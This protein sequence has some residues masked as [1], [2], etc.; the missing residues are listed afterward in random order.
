MTL[1]IGHL[2]DLH[3]NGSGLRHSKFETAL[4]RAKQLGAK[5]IVLTGDLTASGKAEEFSELAWAL[6]YLKD[7]E[8]TIVPGNH[9]AGKEFDRA[10]EGPS[11]GRFR[12]TSKEPVVLE[13]VTIF[14]VDT[15]FHKRALIFRALGRVSGHNLP[16]SKIIE[17]ATARTTIIA[18]HHGPQSHP[19]QW[20][21]GLVERERLNGLLAS[22]PNLHVICGHDHRIFD[23]GRVHVAAAV[24]H[25]SDP[26]RL[27]EAS[28]TGFRPTYQSRIE[29]NYFTL[30]RI[31]IPRD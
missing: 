22:L 6:R 16:V 4:K 5:H 1:L 31:H 17:H 28:S 13:G 2:T 8:V 18:A 23:I 3:L 30:G 26:L 7:D 9:D 27:Y 25:H 20:F 24:A 15:R 14:P 10:L 11:L 29:G 19:L 21:D 12:K